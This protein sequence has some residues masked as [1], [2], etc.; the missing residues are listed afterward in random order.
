MFKSKAPEKDKD[1][2][3]HAGEAVERAVQQQHS[4]CPCRC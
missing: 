1:T 4:E 3:A 2:A